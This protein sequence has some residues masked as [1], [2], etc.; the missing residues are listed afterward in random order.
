MTQL[1]KNRCLV[2]GG[3]G[4]IGG[5]VVSRLL[6]EGAAVRVLDLEAP[7]AA[8]RPGLEWVRGSILDR[9]SVAG[10]LRGVRRVVHAAG[11]AHLWSRD[12]S[13]YGRINDE[14]TRIV[15]EE[16]RRAGVEKLVYTST[17][18]I[19]RP[20]GSLL[21][22]PLTPGGDLPPVSSMAGPY[23]RSKWRAER[24]ARRAAEEGLPVVIVYPTAPIGAGDRNRT[25]P[26]RMIE[27]FLFHPP[28]FFLDC[29][30]NLVSVRDVAEGHVRAC[31]RG[32]RGDRFIL[33]GENL[34]LGGFL[35]LLRAEAGVKIPGRRIPF[36]AARALAAA[37]EAWARLT[38]RPPVVSREGV[39]LARTTLW[40]D[41]TPLREKL[42][43]APTAVAE[44][45][46]EAVAWLNGFDPGKAEAGRSAADRNPP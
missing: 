8:G 11:L 21:E 4:F 25:A 45:L 13:A 10:A 39:R 34:S 12:E 38:G 1:E 9:G 5:A 7:A 32:A 15:L 26:T 31:E 37:A 3:A 35:D 42:G 44:A 43:V 22:E 28:P 18:A 17:E 30:L 41:S 14:G 19:L 27:Q 23:T 40:C 36:A 33:G 24:A 29:R 20:A 2:T 46:R 16:S 6:E